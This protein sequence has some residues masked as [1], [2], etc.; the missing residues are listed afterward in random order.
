MNKADYQEVKEHINILNVAYHLCLELY[1][2]RGVEVKA[3][4]PFCGYNKNSKTPTLILNPNTNRYHCMRCKKK[5]YSIGLYANVRGINQKQAY[6]E[7][8]EKECFGENKSRIEI[9]PINM[10]ADIEVRDAV[11]R[12]FL[13][14][15]KL[16]SS[17]RGYLEKL[18]LLK[19]SIKNGLY[20]SLPKN[21]I[22]RRLVAYNLSKKYNLCGIPGVYQEEDFNWCFTGISGIL[23]PVFDENGL[24]QGLSIKLDKEFNSSKEI[25]FSSNDKINGTAARNWILKGNFQK[26]TDNII[27]TNNLLLGNFIRENSD[28]AIIAF[29]NITNSYMILKQIERAHINNITFVIR[30]EDKDDTEHIISQIIEDLEPLKYNFEIKYIDNFRDFFDRDFNVHYT[31]NKVA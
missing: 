2:D 10:I 22:K 7:L 17:H 29:Q 4:C 6:R 23:I 19:S 30:E 31:L 8:L 25:W 20:R 13:N 26:N 27:I 24:I 21:Y 16:E 18:G 28:N 15:L 12:E 3:I 9:S 11:Y 14:M 1:E 5:G